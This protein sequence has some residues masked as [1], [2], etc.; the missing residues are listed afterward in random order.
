MLGDALMIDHLLRRDDIGQCDTPRRRL[1][2]TFTHHFP[3][4]M[5]HIRPGHNIGHRLNE[6][7]RLGILWSDVQ[8]ERKVVETFG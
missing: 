5:L 8:L 7:D 3:A 2:L 6:R 4:D 1:V